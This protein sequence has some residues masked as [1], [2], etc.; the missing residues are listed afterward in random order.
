MATKKKTKAVASK[1]ILRAWTIGQAYLIRTVTMA[2]TGRLVFVGEH[3]LVLEDAAWIADL[4]RYHKATTAENLSEVEPRDGLV[5]IGRGSVVDA[6]LWFGPL[7][8]S[9]K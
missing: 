9:V 7:P 1:A 6:V 3:E 8:R 4:G 2:W 5:I